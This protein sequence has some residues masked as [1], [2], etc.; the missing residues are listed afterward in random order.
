M[1]KSL[2]PFPM[3]LQ[4]ARL[5]N[6]YLA[7]FQLAPVFGAAELAH[8][9]VPQSGVVETWVVESPGGSESSHRQPSAVER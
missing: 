3:R 1:T 7:R 2:N 6:G 9:L 4:V 5:V 8:M